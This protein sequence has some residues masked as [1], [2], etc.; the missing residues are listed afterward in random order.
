MPPPINKNK[1]TVTK[2]VPEAQVGNDNSL[3][4]LSVNFYEN[5]K[6]ICT[7]EKKKVTILMRKLKPMSTEYVKWCG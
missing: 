4:M 5:S 6:R 2:T 3:D 1:C 7:T